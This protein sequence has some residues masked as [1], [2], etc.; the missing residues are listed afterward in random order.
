MASVEFIKRL[1]LF[2][3]LKFRKA[4]IITFTALKLILE[5]VA[6]QAH[7]LNGVLYKVV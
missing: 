2:K 3:I 6:T 5:I 1:I 4:I 7:S